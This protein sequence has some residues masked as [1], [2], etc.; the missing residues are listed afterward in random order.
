MDINFDDFGLQTTKVS[1]LSGGLTNACL[2]VKAKEG[3]FVWRPV[4]EQATL[5]GADRDKERDILTALDAV[6]FAPKVYDSN[7]EGLLVEWFKGEVIELNKA[8]DVAVELLVSVHQLALDGFNDEL[9]NDVMSLKSRILSYWSSLEPE[10]Q[11]NE[12]HAYVD[13]FSQEDEQPL[14]APCLCHFDIGAYN[15]I[16]KEQGYGLIDWEYASI[17]DPSQDLATMIIANQFDVDEVI[18]RYCQL[19]DFDEKKWKQAVNTWTPWVCFMGA[20]WFSLGHQLLK[21]DCYQDLA[22]REMS[23]LK[24]L[25]PLI[26]K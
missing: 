4:S 1:L 12:M 2:K 10:N 18:H 14:F 26:K 21:D 13:Y 17:G 19:Q 3:T 7:G 25:L 11:T 16:V 23:K 6:P 9:K 22:E 24:K 8:K 15:I 5:L 20:L